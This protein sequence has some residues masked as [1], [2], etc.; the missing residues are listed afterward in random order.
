[1]AETSLAKKLL[2]KPEQRVAI[3]QAPE[4]FRAALEVN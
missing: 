1:M 3:M 2:L 4:G